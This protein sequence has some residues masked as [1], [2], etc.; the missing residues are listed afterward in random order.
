ML[1]GL[2]KSDDQKLRIW[3]LSFEQN[4]CE[5]YSKKTSVIKELAKKAS[6]EKQD[7]RPKRPPYIDVTSTEN[8][9]AIFGSYVF[10]GGDS[11]YNKMG[12][13]T[14]DVPEIQSPFNHAEIAVSYVSLTVYTFSNCLFTYSQSF[15]ELV[16]AW[17][18]RCRFGLHKEICPWWKAT[19]RRFEIGE[20]ICR[21]YQK[22]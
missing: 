5:E 20:E 9:L 1:Q 3:D 14:I 10:S 22:R 17:V 2:S 7:T 11:M 4:I 6:S 8:A 16:V 15:F 21:V 12:V 13:M 18:C 19:K